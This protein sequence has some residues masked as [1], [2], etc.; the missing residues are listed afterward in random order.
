VIRPEDY[1]A[2]D[3][4]HSTS[5]LNIYLLIGDSSMK[6]KV[7]SVRSSRRPS[8][9]R[10][11]NTESKKLLWEGK[12]IFFG[13]KIKKVESDLKG[14]PKSN[15]RLKTTKGIQLMKSKTS[16]AS[17]EQTAQ[18]K[19]KGYGDRLNGFSSVKW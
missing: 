3:H 8:L 17:K 2:I 9:S 14:L 11:K 18:K 4:R 19:A 15:I 1:S 5:L 12:A 13:G 6:R 7:R 16:L 10:I